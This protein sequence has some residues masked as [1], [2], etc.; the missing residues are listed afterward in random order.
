MSAWLLPLG[1]GLVMGLIYAWPVIAFATTFRLVAFPDLTVEGSLPLGG[2]ACAV[3]LTHGLSVPEAIAIAAAVGGALG[4]LT[5][6]IH[7]RLHVNKF[8]AGILVVAISYTLS[9]R[10]MQ[11]SNIGLIDKPSFFDIASRFDAT[12]ENPFQLGTLLVLGAIVAVGSMV[13]LRAIKTLRGTRLRVAGSNP[14][15]ARAIGI[16]VPLSIIV[17]LALSNAIVGASGALL[18]MYQ[19]FADVGMGQGVLILALASMT[20]GERVVPERI[21]SIPAFVIVSAIVGSL[22]YQVLIAYAVR[23]G[24]EATDLKLV[25]ALF[26]LA[27]IAVRIRARDDAF[28]EA[29]R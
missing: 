11:A 22:V 26:V 18:A 15:Y 2:A 8:L 6:L 29:V 5:A 25:T 9:L 21:L 20:L 4:A 23:L 16:N 1:I 7:T 19:G 13:A 28:L 24:L 14:E 3:A 12:I 27:V 17:A 10:V